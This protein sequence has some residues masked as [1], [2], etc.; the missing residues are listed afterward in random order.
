MLRGEG[1]GAHSGIGGMTSQRPQERRGNGRGRRTRN[2]PRRASRTR[3]PDVARLVSRSASNQRLLHT[4]SIGHAL[5]DESRSAA[6]ICCETRPQGH[7]ATNRAGPA[8]VWCVVPPRARRAPFPSHAVRRDPGPASGG[9]SGRPR[10]PALALGGRPGE[11]VSGS[12]PWRAAVCAPPA[13]GVDCPRTLLGH[14]LHHVEPYRPEELW[15]MMS[16]VSLCRVEELL[17]RI[18]L[19]TR[20]A[21]A[22]G[23]S[24]VLSVDWGH[25]SSVFATWPKR[26]AW[27]KRRRCWWSVAP[28]GHGPQSCQPPV[29]DT[30]P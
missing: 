13:S 27:M 9:R 11:T 28:G 20:P 14:L 21:L 22:K 29:G 1:L 17:L 30:F 15:V 6:S 24:V 23:D 16:E 2:V 5:R 18:A 25:L 3:S 7:L 4:K 12:T 26:H 10:A 8:R 19:Q